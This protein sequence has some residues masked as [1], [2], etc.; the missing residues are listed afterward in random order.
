ME[1]VRDL[2]S[3][4][5]S[6]NLDHFLDDKYLPIDRQRANLMINHQ[7]RE[8]NACTQLGLS[9]LGQLSTDATASAVGYC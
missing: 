2:H 3:W 7:T 8:Q 9:Y 1:T 6:V 4:C 5:L